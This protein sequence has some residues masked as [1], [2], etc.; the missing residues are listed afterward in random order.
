MAK[1]GM[2][3]QGQLGYLSSVAEN[4]LAP[5]VPAGGVDV[6]QIV[7]LDDGLRRTYLSWHQIQDGSL[8]ESDA[9]GDERIRVRQNVAKGSR[10][11]GSVT[12]ILEVGPFDAWGRRTF[13]LLTPRGRLDVVQGIT[14]ITPV[15]TRV[16]GLAGTAGRAV[17]FADRHQFS[18]SR[19]AQPTVARAV[20]GGRPRGPAEH[21]ASAVC[22][23]A[24]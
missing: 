16:E 13:S 22:R 1:N 11:V 21:R 23:R 17:G 18:A 8:R 5:D 10:R 19:D 6:K 7:L 14:V 2:I 24:L 3:L 20:G 15:Y 4:P 12:A 9:A